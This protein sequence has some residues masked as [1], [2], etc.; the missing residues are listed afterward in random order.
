MQTIRR[1][2]L[3]IPALFVGFGYLGMLVTDDIGTLWPWFWVGF[4]IA[5]LFVLWHL[6]TM[7]AEF[8]QQ[9]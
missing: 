7:V 8:A 5:V 2:I 6:T 9:D 1:G 3:G 4:A